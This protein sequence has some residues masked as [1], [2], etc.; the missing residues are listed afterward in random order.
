MLKETKKKKKKQQESQGQQLQQNKERERK[1]KR[2]NEKIKPL[3]PTRGS[4]SQPANVLDQ[5]HNQRERGTLWVISLPQFQNTRKAKCDPQHHQLLKESKIFVAMSRSFL[6]TSS[7]FLEFSG[8][9]PISI[10]R[11]NLPESTGSLC[12]AASECPGR[13]PRLCVRVPCAVGKGGSGGNGGSPLLVA[14]LVD[15]G[16]DAVCDRVLMCDALAGP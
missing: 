3:K 8:L 6:A 5:E 12:L 15:D 9:N 13:R 7:A 16:V 11:C 4:K 1:K 14:A 2:G 10:K